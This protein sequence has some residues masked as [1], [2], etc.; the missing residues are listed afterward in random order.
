[1]KWIT[2]G[3]TALTGIA[4]ALTLLVSCASEGGNAAD[5]ASAGTDPGLVA[6]ATAV[7]EAAYRGSSTEPPATAPAPAADKEIWIISAF[8]QVHALAYQSEQLVEAGT[9]IGWTTRVCDGRNNVNGGWSECIRQATAAGAEGIVLVSV[10]CAPVRQALVEARQ[11]NVKI[12]SFSGFDCDDPTQGASTPLFDAPASYLAGGGS[13]ADLYTRLG[14]LRA[15]IVISKT[16]GSAKVLHVAFQD[17]AFGTYLA[18]GFRKRIEKCGGC[19]IVDT[20]SIVPPDVPNI[21]QRFETALAR[22]P[23][24]SV[25]AVDV[26]Y[27]FVAGIQQALVTAGRPG[28]LVL[29]SECQRNDLDYIRSGQGE[30]LCVGVSSGYRSYASIDSLNRVFN[31]AAAVPAGVGMQIVDADNNLPAPGSEYVGTIDFS[32]H[33]QQAW[34]RSR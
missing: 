20:V 19:T 18:D 12:A 2:P 34:G 1:M 26:D 21:R 6:E 9:A 29:G 5:P 31:G 16:G 23:E 8:Q 24:A 28:L 25:V 27:F 7:T 33:Y 3:R 10:D 13:I 32:S 30:E 15:D 14:E 4:L 22:H 17:V 11:A